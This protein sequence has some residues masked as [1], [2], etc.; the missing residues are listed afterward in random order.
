MVYVIYYD[1][2]CNIF[3]NG[4]D[5]MLNRQTYLVSNQK[6]LDKILQEF[7]AATDLP[8]IL[9]DTQGNAL[10]SSHGFT[11]FCQLMRQNE[12]T[13]K[14]CQNCDVAGGHLALNNKRATPYLCHAGLVD[15]SYPIKLD[16]QVIAYIIC[17]QA[18][19]KDGAELQPITEQ[20][21]TL[22][23]NAALKSA[24]T[25][26]PFVNLDKVKAAAKLLQ[27]IINNYLTDIVDQ[28]LTVGP[29]SSVPKSVQQGVASA[30]DEV[31]ATNNQAAQTANIDFKI[32]PAAAQT[33]IDHP[34]KAEI[35]KAIVYINSHLNET[36]TLNAVA[37]HVFLSSYYLSKLFKKEMNINF[38]DYVNRK[39]IDRAI[40]LL[41]DATWSID[42]IAHN[43]GFSQTSYFS[44]TFKKTTELSPSQYRKQIQKNNE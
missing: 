38:V 37:K 23:T 14:L 29:F 40:I 20:K 28:T 2:V 8:T 31:W 1:V 10:T 3:I 19:V 22:S 21:N 33:V 5:G 35:K 12:A 13:Q 9:V 43:L 36:I 17:G 6:V 7:T 25:A 26:L 15:F 11:P 42:S 16:D 30:N 44:K 4:G 34:Q 24:Y 39:K 27:M 32:Q 18:K 41:Q